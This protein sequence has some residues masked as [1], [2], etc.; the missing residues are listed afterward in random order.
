MNSAFVRTLI[1]HE[2]GVYEETTEELKQ[3]IV[4]TKDIFLGKVGYIKQVEWEEMIFKIPLTVKRFA[5]E[6]FD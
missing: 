1:A 6:D 3:I 4:S 5:T 2:K